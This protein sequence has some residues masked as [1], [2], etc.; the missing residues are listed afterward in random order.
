MEEF[1][2]PEQVVKPN[3]RRRIVILLAALVAL[4]SIIFG[5]FYFSF[6]NGSPNATDI[7]LKKITDVKNTPTPFPFQE[8]TIPY[9]RSREYKNTLSELNQATETSTY[10]G[11][12]TSFDSDGF[13]VNGYLT[14]PKGE[15]PEGGWPAVVFVHGYIPPASYRTLENYSQ[16]V[17]FLAKSGFVVFKIDLRGHG[18]SE[19]EPGGG[20]YSGDYIIDTL[21]A[22]SALQES[23]FVNPEKIGFWGHSMAGNVVSRAMASSPDTPAVAIW[24][25]AVYTYEDFSE[26]SIEDNSY[27][28]PPADSPARAKRNEMFELYGQFDPNSEFWR[29]VPMTNY[30]KEIKGV[31]SLNHA[32]DDNVV[33]IEYSRNL[34][35]IL[36]ENSVRFELNE[37]AGGGHNITGS[38]FN[39]AMQNTVEFFKKEL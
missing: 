17:D 35:E 25:G 27:Q 4:N 21:N 39:E 1:I 11:Y 18:Q 7:D 16:H 9:L 2:P 13:S 33:S 14:I 26:F 8:M 29:Q 10:T 37:Y 15:E 20:Y 22:K 36:K 32:R 3:K 28:P 24:A 23:S 5:A 34:A 12:L 30:L 6:K 31:I 19:G 38:Y